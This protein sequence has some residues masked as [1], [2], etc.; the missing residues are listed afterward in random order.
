MKAILTLLSLLMASVS[1]SESSYS[2]CEGS[3]K[4]VFT[5]NSIKGVFSKPVFEIESNGK[6]VPA[7]QMAQKFYSEE[8]Q[9]YIFRYDDK[10]KE[11][12]GDAE[13]AYK[14][15]Q[16]KEGRVHS[17]EQTNCE[18]C[19][20]LVFKHIEG[21]CIPRRVYVKQEGN[22]VLLADVE[23]CK[24]I[25]DAKKRAQKASKKSASCLADLKKSQ[26]E[27]RAILDGTE[28]VSFY[29][30]GES[31]E[32]AND[33]INLNQTLTELEK[34]ISVNDEVSLNEM[35]YRA[36]LDSISSKC[37][38]NLGLKVF[39]SDKGF[40]ENDDGVLRIDK[41]SKKSKKSKRSKKVNKSN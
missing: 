20:K 21:K 23:I 22:D 14:V 37:T 8:T 32:F 7:K 35:K 41:R 18:N 12:K 34:I 17:I 13:F 9:E 36:S 1:A 24:N 39:M 26:I 5:R 28:P 11:K 3:V 29:S 4:Q 16:D 30:G 27:I 25:L 2:R 33:V 15:E 31:S 10:T 19:K 6:L 40:Y 38:E